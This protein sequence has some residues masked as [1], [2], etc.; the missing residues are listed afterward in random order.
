LVV[1]LTLVMALGS[2]GCLPGAA[3]LPDSSGIVYTG[4]KE[5]TKLIHYDLTRGEQKILVADTRAPT[6]WPAV[7]PD[8]KRIAVA[9]IATKEKNGPATL[10]VI[11]YDRGGKEVQRSKV[12][13]WTDKSESRGDKD[14]PPQLFWGP[15]DQG[16]IIGDAG[17]KNVGI[18]DPKMDRL[19]NLKDAWLLNFAG[20]P[21]RPDGAGFLV[22][23][24]AGEFI[25]DRGGKTEKPPAFS[26]VS[27]DGSKQAIKPP[28][29]L[30]DK[31]ALQKEKDLNKLVGLLSPYAYQSGW[32]DDVA[33]VR[34][35]VDR[36]RYFTKKGEAV[37]DSVKPLVVDGRV[38]QLQHKFPGGQAEVRV[39][40][41]FDAEKQ[42]DRPNGR[43]RIEVLKAGQEKAEVLLEKAR[44]CVPT[45]SPNGRMLAL[46]CVGD[47]MKQAQDPMD[48]LI[49][50][51]KGAVVAK[52]RVPQ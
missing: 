46:W 10:Q 36:L 29:L 9:H 50:N 2:A 47:K 26:L 24:G 14:P 23:H 4:G 12:F 52:L 11:L 27:W 39:V 16:V 34:W 25:D 49:V 32:D 35:N 31:A 19:V 45:V 21:V 6:L 17:N 41:A 51:D 48:I 30:L 18:Y 28:P 42:A 13:P 44:L 3:W 38:V 22:M 1:A 7:S 33:W 40:S 20:G 15:R 8:G 5:F 37:I 43:L